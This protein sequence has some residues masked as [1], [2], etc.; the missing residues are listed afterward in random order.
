N[1]GV[2]GATMLEQRDLRRSVS[3]VYFTLRVEHGG[4][5]EVIPLSLEATENLEYRVMTAINKLTRPF[6]RVAILDPSPGRIATEPTYPEL[7][8]QIGQ[9]AYAERMR[10]FAANDYRVAPRVDTLVV[11]NPRNITDGTVRSINEH[12]M[13]G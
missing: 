11:I 12:V 10:P 5:Q 3:G 13:R 7:F 1:S 2:W 4:R 8:R 6:K 9:Y